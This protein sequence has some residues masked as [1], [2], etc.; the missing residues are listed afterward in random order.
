MSTEI[1]MPKLSDTMTEG[2]L[3]DWKKSVGDRVERGEIIAEV[4]TDKANMELEA[5][6]SG[7]LLEVRVKPGEMAPV[8][9]VI[10]IVGEAGEKAAEGEGAPAAPPV[11]ES[12]PPAVEPS[13]A[14]AVPERIMEPPKETA[15][16][17]P[18]GE[19]GA[20]ASPLVRRLAREKGIDLALV[21][22][23]GPE[24]R[25]I[26]EDLDRYHQAR[27]ARS[28][29]RG[30]GEKVPASGGAVQPLSRMRGAIA[31]LVSESWRDIPHFT[32]T[33][34]ID[35]GEAENVRRELK[36][37]GT[38]VSLNDIVIKAAAKVLQRFPLVNA[39]FG[40][41]GIVFHDQVNIGFAVSLDDGLLV[42]VIQG[43]GGLSLTEIA[44][45][46]RELIERAR[47]GSISEAEISGGTFSVSN[48][49]MFGVKEFTAIIHPPQGAV[50]AVGAVQDE[51]VVKGGQVVAARIMRATVSADHRLIDGAYAARFMAEL[52]RV[53]E[54][55]VVMLG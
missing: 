1:T 13:P 40:A 25:I 31:R 38:M 5:F 32:V 35:M 29:E 11:S 15:V 49:G 51:A 54:N 23:S 41:D 10:A 3:I 14:E 21:T 45:R 43:C 8:G 46:S 28:E 22:G 30:E 16:E 26:Q 27:G 36:V 2:R 55:P 20:K 6:S 39:S 34:A 4:E 33:V 53:L 44:A 7:V 24:G 37:A 19:G 17:A 9:T 12:Q 48:L 47:G 50:L 42:P 52:K 18:A